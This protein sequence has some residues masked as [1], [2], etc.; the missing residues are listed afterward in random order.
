MQSGK[1]SG[2][3]HA[4]R[5]CC[6]ILCT[7]A[8]QLQGA[9]QKTDFDASVAPKIAMTLNTEAQG[10]ASST[11]M[12]IRAIFDI[13]G[14]QP[15]DVNFDGSPAAAGDGKIAL[16]EFTGNA[17]IKNVL[18]PSIQMF[19]SSGNY[20]PNPA[21]TNKDS[22]ALGIGFTAVPAQF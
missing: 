7:Q 3:S 10:D 22:L 20:H 18:N 6:S 15:T 1:L 21:N 16:C 17:I 5:V 4:V 2:C 13:G 12:Q 8:G 11:G 14:C 19:D 9:I